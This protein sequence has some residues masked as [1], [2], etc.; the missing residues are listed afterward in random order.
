MTAALSVWRHG[1]ALIE[2][3]V[4]AVLG[5]FQGGDVSP[6]VL[7]SRELLA[8]TTRVVGARLGEVEVDT[9]VAICTLYAEQGMRDDGWGSA[10]KGQ[11]ARRLYGQSGGGARE[12]VHKALDNLHSLRITIGGYDA[13]ADEFRPSMVSKEHLLRRVVY[14][15]VIEARRAGAP[16]YSAV[17]AG[18]KRDSTVKWQFETWHVRQLQHGYWVGLDWEK[19]LKLNSTA[20]LL[21]IFFQS[22]RVPFTAIDAD[23]ETLF[24]PL[25]RETYS[26][27]GINCA[28]PRD[29]KAALIRAGR[30]VVKVD[31]LYTEF[32]VAPDPARPG[33]HLLTVTRS[34][35]HEDRPPRGIAAQ[36]GVT[37]EQL[38]MALVG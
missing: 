9:Y 13:E 31:D 10:T 38:P 32:T 29:N 24:V 6:L 19:L 28:R 22:P 27:L 20:K 17:A 14:D 30:A 25:S 26:A 15:D 33:E 36:V 23:H 3:N 11:L 2:G 34:R 4:A 18:A 12:Q 21:W 7:D 16:S 37:Y 8:D 1:Q 35:R 5:Q